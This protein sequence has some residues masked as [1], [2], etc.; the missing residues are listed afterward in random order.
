MLRIDANVL[1]RLIVNDNAEMVKTAQEKVLNNDCYLSNEVAAEV[2]YVLTKVYQIERESAANA[3]LQWLQVLDC[4]DENVLK[5]ALS[6]FSQTRLD[7][8][9]CL[10]AAYKSVRDDD[11]FSFDKKLLNYMA[12]L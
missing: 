3:V 9:D 11:I 2:I 10:L 12:R 8:V 4:E 5:Q 6:V 1:V 7:F